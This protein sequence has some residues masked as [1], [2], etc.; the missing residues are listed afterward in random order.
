MNARREHDMVRG[1]TFII[2]EDNTRRDT[3]KYPDDILANAM[4]AHFFRLRGDTGNIAPG[5]ETMRTFPHMNGK[6]KIVSKRRDTFTQ[7]HLFP[8]VEQNAVI[9]T[10]LPAQRFSLKS[11]T[12][13]VSVK[14]APLHDEMCLPGLAS[15]IKMPFRSV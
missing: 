3:G 6:A 7:F 13:R 14:Q 11:S 15:Q 8:L 1:N 5:I 10:Q 2:V 12:I 4:N 9:A